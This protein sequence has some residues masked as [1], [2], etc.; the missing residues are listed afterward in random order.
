MEDRGQV[1]YS[2]KSVANMFMNISEILLSRSFKVCLE[3]LGSTTKN[4][5]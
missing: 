5:Q 1:I 3:K 4:K 2:P